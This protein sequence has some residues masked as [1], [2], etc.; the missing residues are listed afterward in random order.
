LNINIVIIIVSALIALFV[1]FVIARFV[2]RKKIGEYEKIGKKILD[3]AKKALG[4]P[5]R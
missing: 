5:E 1:G 2:Q 3:D 4:A